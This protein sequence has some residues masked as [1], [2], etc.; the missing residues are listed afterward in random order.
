[1]SLLAQLGGIMNYEKL[2]VSLNN[3]VI[4]VVLNRPDKSN[5]MNRQM[6][7][8]IREVFRKL[9]DMPEA[10][11]VILSGAGKHFNAGI[12]LAMLSDITQTVGGCQAHEREKLRS[13]VRK[14]KTSSPVSKLVESQS[15][16]RFTAHVSAE[17]LIS[18]APLICDIARPMQIL[19]SKRLCALQ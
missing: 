18:C 19:S 11:A 2:A 8:E 17:A 10:R 16:Q 1:M 13:A 7:N 9:N 3:G 14:R 12:D 4:N 5:A 6:W 15:S